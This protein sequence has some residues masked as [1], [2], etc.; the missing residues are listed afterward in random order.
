VVWRIRHGHLPE[1]SVD[2]FSWPGE[3][4]GATPLGYQTVA[5]GEPKV[6]TLA[7]SPWCA[8]FSAAAA[9]A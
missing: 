7:S 4:L 6:P 1:L 3:R 9:G 8:T 2:G 5:P